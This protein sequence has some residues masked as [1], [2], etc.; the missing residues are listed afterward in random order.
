MRCRK[1]S[2]HELK[3]TGTS[4]SVAVVTFT[5]HVLAFP[6]TTEFTRP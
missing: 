3:I 5:L 2:F 1:S 4:A 6:A